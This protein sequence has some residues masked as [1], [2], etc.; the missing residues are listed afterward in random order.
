MKIKSAIV[1][2]LFFS[3]SSLQAAMPEEI[4]KIQ[5]AWAI[6]KYQTSSDHQA[7]AFENL[8]ENARKLTAD[9]S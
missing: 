8:V 1:A 5:S 2:L 3:A 4:E 6:A 9:L 7:A